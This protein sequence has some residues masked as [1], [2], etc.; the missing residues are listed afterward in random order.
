MFQNFKQNHDY[1][2]ILE[3]VPKD[4]GAAYLQW[5]VRNYAYLIDQFDQFRQNDLLGNPKTYLY[6]NYGTF[7]PTTLRYIKVAGDLSARFGDL[8]RQ[9]ILEIGGGYGGQCKIISDMSGF[10]S[11]TI[12]DLP[13]PNAL[14]K[15]YLHTLGVK[16]VHFVDYGDF[17]RL[18]DRYD[19]LI[20]NYSF[21]EFGRPV[22]EKYYELLKLARAGYITGNFPPHPHY[23]SKEE[24]WQL[25][26]A[27]GID[28]QAEPETPESGANNLLI[29]WK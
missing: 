9:H 16:D 24:L 4:L 27:W 2:E 7:S 13:A 6:K 14:A 29:T 28:L 12:I 10:A 5:I 26:K 23:V 15:K 19:I 3:H 11:Y 22:Q 17:S 1:N 8:S 21:L 20:S 25:T 18:K